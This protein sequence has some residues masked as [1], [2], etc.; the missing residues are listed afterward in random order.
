[1]QLA[2]PNYRIIQ[3]SKIP[4]P[5]ILSILSGYQFSL[6]PIVID[7]RD[8]DSEIPLIE[9]LI[10]YFTVNRIAPFPYPCYVISHINRVQSELPFQ[11]LKKI[12]DCPQFFNKK[13]KQP[14]VKEQAIINKNKIKANAIY[15]L[16]YQEV[17]K[18]LK[19]YAQG[20]RKLHE[21]TKFGT[22]LEGLAG[23]IK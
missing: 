1:L 16:N 21:M 22:F 20:H 13:T 23:K 5:E 2:L 8:H 15:D 17:Q 18:S 14:N 3:L 9:L 6:V 11:I 4:F 7:I 19:K 12:E 10:E